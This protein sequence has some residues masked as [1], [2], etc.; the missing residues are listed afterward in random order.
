ML[1]CNSSEQ[2]N[3]WTNAKQRILTAFR[4]WNKTLSC[5]AFSKTRMIKLKLL[6]IILAATKIKE[7]RIAHDETF[8]KWNH[9]A[10]KNLVARLIFQGGHKIYAPFITISILE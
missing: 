6:E 8:M 10:T 1:W 5:I 9:S 7:W 2:T 4:I 3:N